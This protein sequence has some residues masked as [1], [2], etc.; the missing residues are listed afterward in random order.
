MCVC[1]KKKVFGRA[2]SAR[3][4]RARDRVTGRARIDLDL[5]A[6]RSSGAR[7]TALS[8]GRR[9]GAFVPALF[10]K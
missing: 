10:Q 8:R 4:P 7:V 9:I 6:N 1:L 3:A 5:R 2:H